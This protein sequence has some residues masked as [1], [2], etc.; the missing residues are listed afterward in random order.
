MSMLHVLAA[1]PGPSCMLMSR[2]DVLVSMLHEH[3]IMKMDADMGTDTYMN[4]ETYMDMDKEMNMDTDIDMDMDIST[5]TEKNTDIRYGRGHRTK[6]EK[7][8]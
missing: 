1:W 6:D 7:P 5:E 3:D 4:T 2:L 8:L